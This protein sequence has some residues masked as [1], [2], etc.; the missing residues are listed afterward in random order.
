MATIGHGQ[1]FIL[2][3]FT[4]TDGTRDLLVFKKQQ[5]VS[6]DPQAFAMIAAPPFH[7]EGK[8]IG[9]HSLIN[10]SLL[11]A[12]NFPDFRISI[13][14]GRDIRTLHPGERGLFHDDN[15]VE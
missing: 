15:P 8:V 7:I 10:G 11:L 14:I 13:R 6:D 9:C 3:A 4:Q 5:V 2:E 12:E 1:D